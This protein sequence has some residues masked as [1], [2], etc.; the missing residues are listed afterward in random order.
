MLI[1]RTRSSVYPLVRP[2]SNNFGNN[3]YVCLSVIERVRKQGDVLQLVGTQEGIDPGLQAGCQGSMAAIMHSGSTVDLS[4]G[5]CRVTSVQPPADF[6]QINRPFPS[7]C[8]LGL[9]SVLTGMW[10]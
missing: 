4:S 5:G 8:W 1:C 9:L 6:P 7:M 3:T 2:Q 10:D